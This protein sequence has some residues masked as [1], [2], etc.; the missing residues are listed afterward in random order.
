MI[1][2]IIFLISFL[3][4]YKSSCRRENNHNP[5]F[6]F[7]I[8]GVL[9]ISCSAFYLH[10]ASEISGKI[11]RSSAKLE[12]YEDGS[13]TRY[14]PVYRE[15]H[16]RLFVQDKWSHYALFVISIILGN[17]SLLFHAQD[18]IRKTKS[19]SALYVSKGY[20]KPMRHAAET[21]LRYM[22]KSFVFSLISYLFG[23]IAVVSMAD[24]SD[25][26]V[27]D[28]DLSAGLGDIQGIDSFDPVIQPD[29]LPNAGPQLEEVSGYVKADGTVVQDYVRTVADGTTSNNLSG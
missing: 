9:L 25:L 1:I 12:A 13:D 10:E 16:I 27:P 3:P 2:L 15:E 19:V 18:W 17:L 8:L 29:M 7:F 6:V 21:V 14:Y 24:W 4:I 26:F 28:L 20:P 5:D 22:P 11:E 23:I